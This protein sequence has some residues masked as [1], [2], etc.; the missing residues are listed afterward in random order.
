M[1]VY[2]YEEFTAAI[3]KNIETGIYKPGHKLPSVRSIMETYKISIGTVQKGYEYLQ[4]K[5]LIESI[6][7]SGFYVSTKPQRAG[8]SLA[9]HKQ[10]LVRDAVF[11][12]HLDLTT[13]RNKSRHTLSEF[14]VAAPGDYLIPQK[15]LL[16]TM[17][18]VIREEGVGL[19]RYYPS[20][21][22]AALKDNIARHAAH[23][24]TILNADELIITDGA[25]QALYLDLMCVF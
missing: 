24:R 19:L 12:H 1:K 2:R 15:L 6:P 7:K 11:K 17:Q 25:L 18:Q 9:T 3:E 20:G 4:I 8:T 21:G 14:N 13:S 22:S 10:P 23:H 5:G 16:R